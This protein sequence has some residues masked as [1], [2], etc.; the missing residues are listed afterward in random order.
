MR[1][2]GS[3]V[4]GVRWGELLSL[5]CAGGL[6]PKLTQSVAQ[7]GLLWVGPACVKV[8]ALG[9]KTAFEH[10]LR[11]SPVTGTPYSKPIPTEVWRFDQDYN[12]FRLWDRLMVLRC[13]DE[14]NDKRLQLS[15][16]ALLTVI[17]N[18]IG[19]MAPP[20]AVEALCRE[21]F[22]DQLDVLKAIVSEREETG[23]KLRTTVSLGYTQP[24][25][26]H[27]ADRIRPLV[28]EDWRPAIDR[29]ADWKI[30]V[31]KAI[32]DAPQA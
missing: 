2:L 20:E 27:E 15:E 14:L 7:T 30:P 16:A 9:P 17:R 22:G 18:R 25:S 19:D 5:I 12:W 1:S 31:W 29:R 4:R 6:R 26:K 13:E 21:I 28:P 3:E 10:E 24:L 23:E 32:E 8:L 11:C